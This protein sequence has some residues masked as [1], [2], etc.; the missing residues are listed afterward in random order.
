M[1]IAMIRIVLP[2]TGPL[3]TLAKLDLLDA[4][5]IF[6]PNVRIVLTDYVEFEA[7]R[8]HNEFPDARAIHEFIARNYGRIEIERTGLGE[9]YKQQ[10]LLRERLASSPELAKQL[11]MTLSAPQDLGEATI[12]QYV[13]NLAGRPPGPPVLILAEDDYFLRELAP[14]PGNVHVVS[15]RRFLQKLPQIAELQ[16]N[17]VLWDRVAR[18]REGSD[19]AP[20]VDCKASKI[21]T[22]WESAIDPQAAAAVVRNARRHRP[23]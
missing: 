21:D 3:I 7:T 6:K 13:R 4:L 5:L 9:V 11:G 22:D 2:D 14:L 10:E 16:R 15:T 18:F 23:S 12:V 19:K 17:P 20:L 8:R 1:T